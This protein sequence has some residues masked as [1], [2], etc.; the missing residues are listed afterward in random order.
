MRKRT[1]SRP[2]QNIDPFGGQATTTICPDCGEKIVDALGARIR[3]LACPLCAEILTD[4]DLRAEA[5]RRDSGLIIH[6]TCYRSLHGDRDVTR[7]VR[8][9]LN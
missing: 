1:H 2:W 9:C 8:A 3:V 7:I 4:E 6:E 5:R